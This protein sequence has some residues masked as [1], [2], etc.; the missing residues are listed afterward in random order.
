MR[1]SKL[2]QMAAFLA[3]GSPV[4]AQPPDIAHESR[5]TA[6]NINRVQAEPVGS[7]ARSKAHGQKCACPAGTPK[8]NRKKRN[9]QLLFN[10]IK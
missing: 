5:L 1:I 2:L 3:I 8:C 10:L 9:P 4:W 6:R 7:V